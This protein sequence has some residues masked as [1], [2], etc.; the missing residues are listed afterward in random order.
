MWQCKPFAATIV[1]TN[2]ITRQSNNE[3]WWAIIEIYDTSSV[4]FSM[5]EKLWSSSHFD[6]C[7]FCRTFPS[8]FLPQF[9]IV[10]D[11]SYQLPS[12]RFTWIAFDCYYS[13]LT[14][15][16]G[17]TSNFYYVIKDISFQLGIIL[18]V[19][20][21]KI[22]PLGFYDPILLEDERWLTLQHER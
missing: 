18:W 19:F 17:R 6:N 5:I 11:S 10:F 22:Y 15:F 13:N 4:S 12:A 21:D 7:C 9:S 16:H 14:S 2:R 8:L 3:D 1:E 20:C